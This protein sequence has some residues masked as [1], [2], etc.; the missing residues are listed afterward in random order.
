MPSYAVL[1]FA[2][3]NTA[4]ALA[5]RRDLTQEHLNFKKES[6]TNVN[7]FAFI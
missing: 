5:H 7:M 4:T 1:C 2:N 3:V 6:F